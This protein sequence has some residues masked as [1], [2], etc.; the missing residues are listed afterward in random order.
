[1][2]IYLVKDREEPVEVPEIPF[3][4]FLRQFLEGE[5]HLRGPASNSSREEPRHEAVLLI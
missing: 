3:Q 5:I 4:V 2:K 1:L